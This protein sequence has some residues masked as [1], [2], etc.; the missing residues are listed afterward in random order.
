MHKGFPAFGIVVVLLLGLVDAPAWALPAGPSPVNVSGS[1]G[2]S[3][4]NL[5]NGDGDTITSNQLF[6]SISARS[7]L[8]QPWFATVNGRLRLTLD[9]T[10]LDRGG[11]NKATVSTGE[12]SLNLLP[13]SRSP[14]TLAFQKSNSQVEALGFRN[15]LVANDRDFKTQRLDL[16]QSYLTESGHR[17]QFRYGTSRWK[18]ARSEYDDKTYGFEGNWRFPKHRIIAKANMK[19]ANQSFRNQYT[20]NLLL[21]LDHFWYPTRALRWDS[22]INRVTLDTSLD[23]PTLVKAPSDS[24]S[25]LLQA[26]SFFF[27]RP[28][29]SPWSVSGGVRFSDLVAQSQGNVDSGAQSLNTTGGF[30]YQYTKNLRFD[31]NVNTTYNDAGVAEAM[32][33]N[34][35]AG[36]LYQSDFRE[37]LATG[38]SY[39]WHANAA[40]KK[41]GGDGIK[42]KGASLTLG[43]NAQKT[44]FL[45]DLTSRRN[46]V[47]TLRLS[48]SQLVT[49]LTQSGD[50]ELDLTRLDNSVALNWS[51]RAWGGTSFAQLSAT[52]SRESGDRESDQQLINFQLT[53]NQKISRVSSL[54]GGV[55]IQRAALHANGDDVTTKTAQLGYQHSRAF[56]VRQ[57][58]FNSDLNLSQASL[59][60]GVDREEW[61]NRL[62]YRI[63][64]LETSMTVQLTSRDGVDTDLVYFKVTRR[65]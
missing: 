28:V 38:F 50:A 33:W 21:D 45:G 57:L 20:E 25:E 11:E 22:S 14:L 6:G 39:Q 54:N 64:L 48:L 29:D 60:N 51:Q 61:T 32:S 41:Q 8:W 59:D 34:S 7:Y 43:H 18:S 44:W 63:G 42:T 12:F 36:A 17:L 53:R 5:K 30:L 27:W 3:Y 65:F 24:Q 15:P 52:D 19:E 58:R 55:T 13:Q 9:N 23:V 47:T 35:R 62:A 2:Y 26:S 10:D 31:A 16:T 1:L 4:R 40:L 37:I 56:G 46:D 49:Q